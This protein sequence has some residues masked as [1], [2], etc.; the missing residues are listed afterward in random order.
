MLGFLQGG[1]LLMR[2]IGSGGL[3]AG[4]K[5]RL[6][7]GSGR[8]VVAAGECKTDGLCLLGL[9]ASHAGLQ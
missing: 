6:L 8:T 5:H 4:G 2:L 1:G 9:L 3:I 7:W